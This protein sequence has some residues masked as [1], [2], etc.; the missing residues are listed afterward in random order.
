[1]GVKV[2]LVPNLQPVADRLHTNVTTVKAVLNSWGPGKYDAELNMDGK[3]MKP[4]GMYRIT[5]LKG[6]FSHM[7]GGFYHDGR[8][9]T[10]MDVVSHYDKLFGLALADNEKNEL[11]EYLKSI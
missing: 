6:L 10:L 2:S 9:A 1:V 7:K 4:D 3:A 8:F 5:P 11:I